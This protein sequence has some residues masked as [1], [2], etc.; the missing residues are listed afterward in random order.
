MKLEFIVGDAEQHKVE[1][2]WSQLWG[3][4]WLA[5]DGVKVQVSGI[6]LSSP[7]RVIGKDESASGWKLRVPYAVTRSGWKQFLP[8]IFGCDYLDIERVHCWTVLVGNAEQHRVVIEKERARWFAGLRPSKYRVFV[9]Q[10]LAKECR[11][12]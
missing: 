10:V 2:F 4:S 12:F 5:V 9:D 1:F 7:T 8:S 3:N 11:G 6:Q